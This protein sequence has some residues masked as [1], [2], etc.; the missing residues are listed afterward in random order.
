[1]PTDPDY[2]SVRQLSP[3]IGTIQVVTGE[4]CRAMSSDGVNWQIQASCESHQQEWNISADEYIPRRY[5][6]YGSWNKTAGFSSLPLD[7]MLDVPG[8]DT[9]KH[10]LISRLETCDSRLPF[11][12]LDHYECWLIDSITSKP[13]VL[14][15][16]AIH[17]DMIP[18]IQVPKWLALS[19]HELNSGNSSPSLLSDIEQLEDFINTQGTEHCWF[20]RKK[21]GV[22]HALTDNF[23]D[24]R[25]EAFPQ[26][27]VNQ[28]LLPEK[29]RG[30]YSRLIKLLS[31][32]LLSLQSLSKPCFEELASLAQHNAIETHKRLGIYPYTLP[33]SILNKIHV[34]LKIRGL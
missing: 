23:S 28:A 4:Y 22:S 1:M 31:P 5:V 20:Y 26:L 7:P 33:D 15:A 11:P 9:V 21:N 24:L 19:Q 8:N 3:F 18:H 30:F 25:D 34:E 6:L 14:V 27:P 13:L 32:R 29:F 12:V 10:S 2:Y 16:S 17:K